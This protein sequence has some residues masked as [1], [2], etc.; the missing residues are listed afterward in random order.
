MIDG[1]AVFEDDS[2]NPTFEDVTIDAYAVQADGFETA[3]D[4]WDA[5]EAEWEN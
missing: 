4:A 5:A 3:A 1:E 2:Q